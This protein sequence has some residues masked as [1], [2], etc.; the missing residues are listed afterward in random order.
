MVEN[1]AAGD[2]EA[3]FETGQQVVPTD[4]KINLIFRWAVFGTVPDELLPILQRT[5]LLEL[6]K[7][8]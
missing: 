1:S 6:D 3:V 7:T 4:T 2:I 8:N 5:F